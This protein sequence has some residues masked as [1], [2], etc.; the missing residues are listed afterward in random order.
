MPQCVGAAEVEPPTA[1]REEGFGEV[2]GVEEEA[3]NVEEAGC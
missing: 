2:R 3:G 1:A